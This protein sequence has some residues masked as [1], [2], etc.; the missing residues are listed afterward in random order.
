MS[1]TRWTIE[2]TADGVMEV[3]GRRFAAN[4][5]GAPMMCNLVC[6]SLNRHT[7]IDDCRTTGHIGQ[8]CRG[9]DHQHITTRL[10]P[11]PDQP[12]DWI[13]HALY[14]RRTGKRFIDEKTTANHSLLIGFRGEP[15]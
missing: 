4:D 13:S 5:E 8:A 14:W 10:A 9:A 2:G 3:D 7:H 11:N 12:K 1:K 6:K 15:F